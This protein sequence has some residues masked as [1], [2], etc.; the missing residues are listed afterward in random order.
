MNDAKHF[1][2]EGGEPFVWR[3]DPTT[4]L[5]RCLDET[6]SKSIGCGY[7]RLE[8]TKTES[9]I[10]FDE[11]II[12]LSGDFRSTCRGLTFNCK[13]GDMLW[14][15]ANNTFTLESET[16]ALLVYVKYP[17]ATVPPPSS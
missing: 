6:S 16:G 17:A 9:E 7:L 3:D 5:T 10:D 8:P 15:P 4:M 13:P 1:S 11:L 12:V 14:I 2:A